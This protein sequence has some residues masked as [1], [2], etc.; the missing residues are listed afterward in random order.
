M[1]FITFHADGY[2]RAGVLL[3][4]GS[5]ADDIVCDLS[6]KYMRPSLDGIEPTLMDFLRAGLENVE[7]SITSH[8]LKTES[9]RRLA[10]VKLEAPLS[11]PRKFFALA[12]NHRD[13]V[14]ER[15]IAEPSKPVFFFKSPK[16]IIGPSDTVMLPENIGGVTYEA[17]LAIFI[18]K[19]GFQIS[20]VGA[21]DHVAGATIFN[22][23][24]ATELIRK[25]GTFE[26]GKNFPTFGP[27]GPYLASRSE[28]KS[29]LDMK[30][31][32]EMDGK[33]LQSGSTKN[34]IFDIP[35]II[36]YLSF[37]EPL[38]PGD[39]IATGTPAGVASTYTPPSWLRPGSTMKASVDGLGILVNPVQGLC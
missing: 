27:M 7:R 22:D 28:I 19:A 38:E 23:I 26:R 25:E 9:Y 30:I 6:C 4:S 29:F 31:T 36:S 2:S 37:I 8:G 21:L 17:E 13:A 39:I 1:R 3:G 5:Q 24:S 32:F 35:K 20:E 15:G 14:I 16:T 34:L 12:F 33:L 10:S 18:G 11:E